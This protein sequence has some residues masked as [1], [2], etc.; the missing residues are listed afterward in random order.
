MSAIFDRSSVPAHLCAVPELDFAGDL[1]GERLV[2]PWFRLAAWTREPRRDSCGV[3]NVES[4]Q[5]LLIP[6]EDFANVFDALES[7]GNV[8]GRLG[9][10]SGWV[11]QASEDKS[12]D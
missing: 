5:S 11:T 1:F 12:Y 4:R 6:R 8:I 3:E 9:T 10:P 7:V 2:K